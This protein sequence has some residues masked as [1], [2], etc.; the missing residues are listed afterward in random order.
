MLKL[1]PTR[2]QSASLFYTG[3]AQIGLFLRVDNFATVNVRKACDMSRVCEFCL[4]K[5]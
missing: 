2:E 4:E 5:V 3:W 1:K